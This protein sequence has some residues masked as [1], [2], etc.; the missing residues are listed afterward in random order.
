MFLPHG[1]NVVRKQKNTFVFVHAHRNYAGR[2]STFGCNK[3]DLVFYDMDDAI[4][5]IAFFSCEIF[6]HLNITLPRD[7]S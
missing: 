6:C 4:S 5:S 7:R 1:P 2:P 3:P